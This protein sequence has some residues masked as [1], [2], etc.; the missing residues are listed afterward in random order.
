M[1]DLVSTLTLEEKIGQLIQIAPFFYIE[2]IDK[3]V[4]GPLL[5]L[6]I[7]E[8][9]I[10]L[11]GSVLGIKDAE[12]MIEVQKTYLEKSRHKIPLMFMADIIHGYKTIFPVPLAMAATFNP[13]LVKKAARISSI[14]AQTAGIHVTFSPMADLTRDPRWGRVVEGFGED[15][16]LN[17]VL[18][19]S[20]VQGYQH[21]GIDKE[22]NLASCVKHFAGYGLSEAGR[23][24][25]TTDVSRL[26]LH[27]YYLTGYKKALDA[28][29]RLVM[30]A[31]NLIEGVPAT[32][33]AYLLREV[34]RDQYQFDGV[35]ISDYDSL[36]ET[37]EH[38]TSK[39]E[40]D[41]ARQ[42]II[43]GLDIEMATAAYFRNLPALIQENK[44]DIA[45]IDEAV[46]RVLELKRDL[47]L[48]DNPYKGASVTK[49]KQLVLS[50]AHKKASLEVALES[51]VLLKNDGGTLP[52]KKEM[53]IALLG[54]YA[55][56]KDTIGPW[57][58][59]GNPSDNNSLDDVLN[60]YA[61]SLYV[62]D[63]LEAH[64]L[65]ETSINDSDILVVAIGESRRESGEAH[66][67]TNIKL[68]NQQERFINDLKQF[69]KKIVLVLFNGRPLDL[70]GVIDQSNAIL[71]TFFLGTCSSE[72]I[73]MLLYN[74]KNP[75]GKLPMSFP[76]NVGQVPIYYNYLNTG[77]PFKNDGNEYTS[78]YLDEK[79]DP[80]F[81]FGYG[82][83]YSQFEFSNLI[84]KNAVFYK[85]ETFQ[86]S[87]DV[88][89]TSA[90]DGYEV[91]QVYLRDMVA[92]VSRPV[93]ELKAFNKVFVK[94]NETVTLEFVLDD[95]AFS[96]VHR[97]LSFKSDAGDFILYVGN[98]STSTLETKI[99][100]KEGK[101]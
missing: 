62:N 94:K 22:G 87:I 40:K 16:Y 95:E 79:N 90:F 35:V 1:K 58:W 60:G 84:V 33:N 65:D 91:V 8:E 47:G 26:N 2:K 21:D 28:G 6:G 17:G 75:S 101:L 78:F 69:N 99:T 96:Y 27:Q 32:T 57:S 38:G 24:Y 20:M 15:P 48:F 93:K 5:D 89:N 71:E 13:N 98:S 46:L 68:S 9:E 63:T 49:A 100:M 82:L 51:A 41:A 11:T 97:D 74:E 64:L 53:K 36:K 76:R 19:A 72:A 83:S 4:F 10:F 34:L 81:S 42:G 55:T 61:A 45:L 66:S 31:F 25:N 77:R 14:E 3:N 86:F 30:T 85:G 52:L 73:A 29:A 39:D 67:K 92:E 7:S 18:A 88:T 50:E 23:D 37:I 56:S 43:A 70:S 54:N 80:L 59:H 12:E 44:V